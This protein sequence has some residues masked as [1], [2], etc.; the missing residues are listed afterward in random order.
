MQSSADPGPE[1][2]RF[3]PCP[4][5]GD[6]GLSVWINL[7]RPAD[8]MRLKVYTTAYRKTAEWDL[9]PAPAGQTIRSL[10]LSSL[11]PAD[12]LYYCVLETSLG[13]IK[14]TWLVLR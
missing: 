4:Y 6:T 2:V 8:S 10:D 14:G 5:R 11:K 9:G 7:L 12:G 3:L 1:A 13:R